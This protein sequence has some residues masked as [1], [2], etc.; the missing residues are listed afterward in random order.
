MLNT[1][2]CKSV[3]QIVC[4]TVFRHLVLCLQSVLQIVSLRTSTARR[5]ISLVQPCV[6][7]VYLMLRDV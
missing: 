2:V 7:E 4:V 1:A 6:M 3:H 5:N